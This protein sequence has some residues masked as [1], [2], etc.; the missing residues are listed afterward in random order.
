MERV[1]FLIEESNQ[2]VPCLLNPEKLTIERATGAQ[3]AGGQLVNHQLSDDPVHLSG[4]GGTNFKIELL[5]DVNLSD[6]FMKTQDV[7]DLTRP[8]WELTEYIRADTLFDS[9]PRVRFIW[10][11]A[12]NI[13]V[14]IRDIS[15]TFER[16]NRNGVPERALMTFYLMRVSEENS[17][18]QPS[19]PIHPT[20]KESTPE[21]RN[22]LR[23]PDASWGVHTMVEDERLEQLAAK[24][25]GR[26]SLWRLIAQ[27][28]QITNPTTIPVGQTLRIP[29]LQTI[30]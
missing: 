2:R 11:K 14:I 8:L 4:R 17:Q 20:L 6:L 12:W 21:Q 5:F 9:L 7:R 26:P 29:P 1:E 23:E 19:D 10:G 28:N 16:V 25:Y 24:Y 18:P 3:R 15:Q 22:Q 30:L 27:A 13:R